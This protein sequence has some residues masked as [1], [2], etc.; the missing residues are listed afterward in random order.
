MAIAVTVASLL[1]KVVE[2]PLETY[3]YALK[4]SSTR[5]DTLNKNR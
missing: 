1:L 3:V 2:R 5:E 4:A